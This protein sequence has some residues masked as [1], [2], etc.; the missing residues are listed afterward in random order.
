MINKLPTSPLIRRKDVF[1]I[2]PNLTQ[3]QL[4]LW[5]ELGII[6]VHRPTP[7]QRR[8]YYTAEIAKVATPP[9]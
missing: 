5:E 8:F 1:A 7:R 4:A 6:H 9:L 2:F 3:Y